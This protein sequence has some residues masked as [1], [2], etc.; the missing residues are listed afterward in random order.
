M[1]KSENQ[2]FHS[3]DLQRESSF[4]RT[5]FLFNSHRHLW[6]QSGK[7]W[8]IYEALEEDTGAVKVRIN[9]H[10]DAG[11][12]S[13]P[14]R[15]PFGFLEIYR[16]ISSNELTGFF[17]LIEADLKNRGVRKIQIKSY[18]EVYD[19]NFGLVEEVLKRLQYSVTQE[20]SSIIPV[21]RKP[22][23]K[24]IKVSE[25]QKL[26]KAK[27]LFS[28]EKVKR[29]YVKEIY[30]FIEACRNE[31]NQSLSMSFTELNKAI[32]NFPRNFSFYRVNDA[33]GSA[34]AAI[35]ISVSKEI[36][37]TF[38]YAHARRFDKVSPVVLL[39]D[40]IYEVAQEQGIEMIDLGTS[41]VNGKV[42]RSLLHF[43]KSIG[44]QTNRKLIFEKT[45][46]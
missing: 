22:F 2:L 25:R 11:E 4:K 35:V 45:L 15:A 7:S 24:K 42:N 3:Y 18:P 23:D 9:F 26:R 1:S 19:K 28:F 21:D 44:A 12:A 27:H 16:K 46:V 20:V 14:F 6:L 36:L 38:Y 31:R 33:S 39:M 34:A 8:R 41:M 5:R 32:S 30:S 10:I 40:G 29:I 17:S 43:K 13:S 37:Y